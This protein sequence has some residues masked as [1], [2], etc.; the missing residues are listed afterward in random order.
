MD[1]LT[2]ANK[3][4]SVIY[5]G[6]PELFSKGASAIHIMK[7]CQ[8]MGR[9]GI[10]T[11]LLLP[12]DRNK[13]E[14]YEYYG[15]VDNFKLTPFPY[16]K[17]TSARN[18]AHGI[19][20]SVYTKFRRRDVDLVVTRNI[21]F[22]YLSTSFLFNIPTVYD[23]HHPPVKGASRLFN[24]FKD[25]KS[26]VRF[27]TNSRGL[28]E[29]YLKRGL[30]EEKL[31]VA[32]NGVDLSRFGD[33]LSKS[34]ARKL[35]GLPEDKKIVSYVG[36]IYEGR[37]IELL[38][39]AA[40]LFPDVLFEI[41]GGLQ[42]EVDRLRAMARQKNADNINFRGHV[43]HKDVPRY[44]YAADALVMP[45][46]SGMTIKGGTVATDFTSPIKL[47]EYMASGRPIVATK[48]PSVMEILRDGE[49]AV[50]VEPDNYNSL[51]RGIEQVLNN[52]KTADKLANA[53]RQDVARYSWETRAK[54]LLNIK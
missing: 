34:E 38:I 18:I 9:L 19:L 44:L 30:P 21:V 25:S 42:K 47:F 26:L 52:Q 40:T 1:R 29:I 36:N 16:F 8:A 51:A 48:I 32:H 50:L 13:S 24:S 35:L 5:V 20:S 12:L 45:Y 14:I 33:P 3:P 54:K 4:K 53:S 6:S 7:M 10:E 31:V 43:P 46:T 23:A 2:R 39:D 11:E 15:I 41:V 27:S 37:G 49:N 17:N 22:T 28:G